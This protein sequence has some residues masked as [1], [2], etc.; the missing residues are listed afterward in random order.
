MLGVY[1]TPTSDGLLSP[2]P[3]NSTA[4]SLLPTISEARKMLVSSC[5]IL[6]IRRWRGM[7]HAYLHAFAKPE[8]RGAKPKGARVLLLR[9]RVAGQSAIA[10]AL[11]EKGCAN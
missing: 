7:R 3:H 5:D 4:F 6:A 9:A 1:S 10:I 11:L 8:I 2:I